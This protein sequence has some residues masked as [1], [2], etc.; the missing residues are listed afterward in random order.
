MSIP[1]V[2]GAA[3]EATE[4]AYPFLAP[5]KAGFV[6]RAGQR[7]SRDRQFWQGLGLWLVA[8]GNKDSALSRSGWIAHPRGPIHASLRGY[9]DEKGRGRPPALE[10]SKGDEVFRKEGGLTRCLFRPLAGRGPGRGRGVGIR[11]DHPSSLSLRSWGAVLWKGLLRRR[12]RRTGG[13][14]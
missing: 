6:D 1:S 3:G 10:G 4:A 12:K 13:C 7:T 11:K 8:G 2:S 5:E 9:R 14:L